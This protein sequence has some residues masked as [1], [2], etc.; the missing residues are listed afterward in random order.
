MHV[1][2]RNETMPPSG[3]IVV[4]DAKFSTAAVDALR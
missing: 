1:G 4:F 3:G 2:C